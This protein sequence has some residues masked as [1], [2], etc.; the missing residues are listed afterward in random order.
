[1]KSFLVWLTKHWYFSCIVVLLAL[2][3]LLRLYRFTEVP[4]G[5]TWDEAAIGYNGF[6]IWNTRR[7]EWLHRLPVSFQS[8]GDY[9]APF[10][11]YLSSFFTAVLGLTPFAVRIPFV[12][13]GVFSVAGA[14]LL[15]LEVFYGEEKRRQLSLLVGSFITF[16]P[17]H[18]HFSRGAF[19]SGL[20]FTFYVWGLFFIFRGIRLQTTRKTLILFLLASMSFVLSL[21]TYHSSKVVIPLLLV[22]LSVLFRNHLRNRIKPIG[23]FIVTFAV[24]MLPLLYDSFWGAGL[25][26]ANVTFFG[27]Q[28]LLSSLQQLVINFVVHFSPAFMMQGATTTFRHSGGAW[29]VLNPVTYVLSMLYLAQILLQLCFNKCKGFKQYDFVIVLLLFTGL[30]PAVITEDVPHGNRALF[31]SIGFFLAAAIGAKRLIGCL[32]RSRMNAIKTGSHGEKNTLV[33]AVVGT[34]CA[35]YFLIFSAYL[36]HYYTVF[37]GLAVDDYPEGYIEAFQIAR[38]YELGINGKP[39]VDKI[40]FTSEY[41]QPYIFALFVRKTNPIAYHGGSLSTY[42]F[43][44]PVTIADFARPKALIVAS[45]S[46]LDIP[47]E[48]AVHRIK[49]ADG[50]TRFLFFLTNDK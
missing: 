11:I 37:P 3:L 50:S 27:Q 12:I 16:S 6:A 32:Q 5:L 15:T 20:A 31:A 24:G 48:R 19:E 33:D 21:Y 23:V 46:D 7:D 10:A 9:K 14:I 42:H 17:W 22:G 28:S 36:H 25:T 34:L 47:V 1:M 4:T 30:V 26:R 38:E 44:D 49:G 29:G 39:K 40:V 8:F 43:A 2:A 13:A 18:L 35:V 41:G 45:G